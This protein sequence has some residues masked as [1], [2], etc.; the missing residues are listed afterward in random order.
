MDIHH[1]THGNIMTNNFRYLEVEKGVFLRFGHWKSSR[2]PKKGTVCLLGGRTE[3]MEKYF[4]TIEQFNQRGFDAFSFDWRGQ[5]LSTR[6]LENGRKGYIKNFNDYV[7]DLSVFIEKIFLKYALVRPFILIGHSMG[8]HIALRFL[9]RHHDVFK[10]GVLMSPMI[11]IRTFPVHRKLIQ[12]I[13]RV[14][15]RLGYDKAY[16]AGNDQVME[17]KFKGNSLTSDKTRFDK[18]TKIAIDNQDI[19]TGGVTF[20]W[21]NAAFDSIEVL[22]QPGFMER[23]KTRIIIFSADND[24]VVCNKAQKRICERL[25]HC[26]FIRISGSKHEIFQEK[27]IIRNQFW[28]AFQSFYNSPLIK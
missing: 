27:D 18:F 24:R 14:F 8:G 21:L 20:G 3:F 1:E 19:S 10:I 12:K 25:P 4:E 17:K 7:V 26:T 13:T 23:I 28:N 5:G 15:A 6:L 9:H 2:N 11:D 22:N 16:I